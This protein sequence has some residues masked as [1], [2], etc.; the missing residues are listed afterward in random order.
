MKDIRESLHAKRTITEEHIKLLEQKGMEGVRYTA[1]MPDIPFL[2]L[3]LVCDVG[4][5]I[6]LAAGI[7]YYCNNGFRYALDWMS[8]IALVG[9]IVGVVYTIYMNKIHE[10]EIATRIQKN[11]SFGLT[12]YAGLAGGVIG[13]IQII[14]YT[15]IPAALVW[16]I[17]GGFL[18]FLT[19]LPIYLSFRKGIVYGVQ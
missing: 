5:L 8:L 6:H 1:M 10:K 18:N 3:A 13:I 19:G 9:V 7:I 12:A 16:M 14:T 17:A 11:L 2:V 4:W 15:T